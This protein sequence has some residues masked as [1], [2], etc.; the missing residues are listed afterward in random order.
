M[1]C[2]KCGYTSFD[3][4]QACPKCSKDL[5]PTRALLHLLTVE[6]QPKP[7]LNSLLGAAESV[8]ET[9]SV[10]P[11]EGPEHLARFEE[12]ELEALEEETPVPEV[13]AEGEIEF[14]MPE[15]AEAKRAPKPDLEAEDAG[16]ELTPEEDAEEIE[17]E[18]EPLPAKEEVEAI[19][20]L[21]IE[22][23]KETEALVEE[24]LE[25]LIMEPEELAEAQAKA[26]AAAEAELPAAKPEEE[27]ELPLEEEEVSLEAEEG[28]LDLDLEELEPTG[29]ETLEI[30][31][32][33]PAAAET[34]RGALGT[35]E[36]H[37]LKP[38][39][40]ED[41]AEE[42]TSEEEL[43]EED[44]EMGLEDL[45]LEGLDLEEAAEEPELPE[46]P[47]FEKG[48]DPESTMI[49]GSAKGLPQQQPKTKPGEMELN[50]I[51][52]SEVEAV[53]KAEPKKEQ[54]EDLELDMTDLELDLGKEASDE[55][56][57]DLE[58]D[59]DDLGLDEDK[60]TK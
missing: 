2:P 31:S 29:E 39:D 58:L 4:N 21:E 34:P 33:A 8:P 12:A 11:E 41:Q 57:E 40:L 48:L 32:R 23:A 3:Y 20:G 47:A 60:P 7:Y 10:I 51:D 1:R 52:F 59:L 55:S 19:P 53:L 22:A 28:D 13:E 42:L 18:L 15:E 5:N 9:E 35:E 30:Q 37:L 36:T 43:T 25:T 50:E 54:A 14:A 16:L 56:S 44:L 26:T 49:M 6:P 17:F 46:E 38:E 45:D 27:L 24:D